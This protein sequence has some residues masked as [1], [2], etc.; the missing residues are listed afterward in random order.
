MCVNSD[1]YIVQ[2]KRLL[3]SMII[4]K[5][6]LLNSKPLKLNVI[7]FHCEKFYRNLIQMIFLKLETTDNIMEALKKKEK[8]LYLKK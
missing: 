5:F 7:F 6:S 8:C 1:V 2:Y 4:K 3:D